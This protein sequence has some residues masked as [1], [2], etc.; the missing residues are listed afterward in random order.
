MKP[1]TGSGHLQNLTSLEGICATCVSLGTIYNPPRATM[2]VANMQQLIIDAKYALKVLSTVEL[3]HKNANSA[4][5][6]AFIDFPERMSSIRNLFQVACSDEFLQHNFDTIYR[7]LVGRRASEI[8][9]ETGENTATTGTTPIDTTP[10]DPLPPKHKQISSAQTGYDDRL[11]NLDKLIAFLSQVTEYQPNEE[12]FTIE[13]LTAYCSALKEF[14]R[15]VNEAIVD[16]NEA[17]HNRDFVLYAPD[18]GIFAIGSRVKKYLKAVL[19]PSSVVY[20]DVSS[21]IF[22]NY[23]S[24]KIIQ[25]PPDIPVEPT[26]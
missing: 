13:S 17:L 8:I 18:T 9:K 7:K 22:R 24:K 3:I 12:R 2:S 11:A 21:F 14:H 15:L 20:K 19:T 23:Q 6:N 25:I 26:N 1:T 16:H 4:R 10:V 5:M